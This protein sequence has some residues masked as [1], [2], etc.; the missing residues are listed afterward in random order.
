MAVH[1]GDPA[2]SPEYRTFQKHFPELKIGLEPSAVADMA[3][4][5]LLLTAEEKE[6]VLVGGLT[7]AEMNERLLEPIH[8]RILADRSRYHVFVEVLG[9]EPVYNDMV[10]DLNGA[11]GATP[12]MALCMAL[13]MT[14]YG[15][16]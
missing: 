8:R 4:S 10:A 12:N 9:E 1:G 13:E 5:M 14:K 16:M 2:S 15:G 7:R 6:R 11:R 3:F